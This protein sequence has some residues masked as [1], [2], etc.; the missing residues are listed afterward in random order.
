MDNQEQRD[1]HRVSRF[2]SK[3]KTVG[4]FGYDQVIPAIIIFVILMAFNKTGIGLALATCWFIGIARLKKNKGS[5]YLLILI[6]WYGTQSLCRA[7]FSRTPVSVLR[8][9]LN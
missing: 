2:L 1:F 7:I 3:P 6:Y 4:G 9:W 8:F 5:S